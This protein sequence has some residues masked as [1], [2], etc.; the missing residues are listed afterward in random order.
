M[1]D[2]KCC[3]YVHCMNSDSLFFHT[4]SKSP[5]QFLS[6]NSTSFLLFGLRLHNTS[7][8]SPSF[9]LFLTRPLYN[10]QLYPF[11]DWLSLSLSSQ[12]TVWLSASVAG[13]AQRRGNVQLAMSAVATG[14]SCRRNTAKLG[15]H[16]LQIHSENLLSERNVIPNMLGL[17]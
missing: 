3:H 8:Q 10:S 15:Q 17:L 14:T 16:S 1:L 12:L 11:I 13:W 4:L 6:F 2:K 7:L 9:S 5:S